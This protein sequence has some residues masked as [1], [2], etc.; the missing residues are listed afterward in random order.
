M[1]RWLLLTLLAACGDDRLPDFATGEPP[2]DLDAAVQAALDASA[3]SDA[4]PDARD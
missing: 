3:L 4:A 2:Y 1:R